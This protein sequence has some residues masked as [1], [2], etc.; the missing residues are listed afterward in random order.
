MGSVF[1]I[2]HGFVDQHG[3]RI[4][5]NQKK[6]EIAKREFE[7]RYGVDQISRT[8]EQWRDLVKTYGM[9]I[10]IEKERMSEAEIKSHMEDK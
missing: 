7:K 1:G 8:P 10:C 3:R 2:N 4:I 9:K 5:S 6:L